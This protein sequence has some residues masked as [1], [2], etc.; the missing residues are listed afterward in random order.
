M[1]VHVAHRV[2]EFLVEEKKSKNPKIFI[3]GFAFKGKPLTSDTRHSPTSILVDQLKDVSKN[4]FG[5]DP[6]VL[7]KEIQR[8]FGVQPC[9]IEEGFDD[10]DCVIVM[11]NHDMYMDLDIFSLLSKTKKPALFYDAWQLF[12]SSDIQQVKGI[13]H[14][15][16]GFSE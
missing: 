15:G 16:I 12:K 10:A 6:A 14:E 8:D 7:P 4:I 11:L 2:K 9:S 3:L 13:L 1:P 5:F